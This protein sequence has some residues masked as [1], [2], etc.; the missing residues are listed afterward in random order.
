MSQ[1]KIVSHLHRYISLWT[2]ADMVG[3]IYTRLSESP[4]RSSE[5]ER[6]SSPPVQLSQPGTNGFTISPS[7][8]TRLLAAT[9]DSS[10]PFPTQFP[11]QREMGLVLYRPLGIQAGQHLNQGDVRGIVREWAGKEGDSGR[12]EV[13]DEDEDLTLGDAEMEGQEA[14]DMD[15]DM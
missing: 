10:I 5:R 12:F 11:Q 3:I 2:E 8:L 9:K 14:G 1:K 6:S 15:I 13:V 7:M 4:S